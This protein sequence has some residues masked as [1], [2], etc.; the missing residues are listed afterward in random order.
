MFASKSLT[1]KRLLDD[2]CVNPKRNSIVIGMKIKKKNVGGRPL[3][4]KLKL[5]TKKR[6]WNEPK[7]KNGLVK[8]KTEVAVKPSTSTE[9]SRKEKKAD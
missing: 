6:K 7:Q 8:K 1:N 5:K 4:K 9:Q 3:N 2:E